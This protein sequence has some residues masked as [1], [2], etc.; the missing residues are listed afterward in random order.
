MDCSYL[1]IIKL[2]SNYVTFCTH[3]HLFSFPSPFIMADQT[4]SH[5][6]VTATTIATITT[7]NNYGNRVIG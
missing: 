1:L 5:D 6:S 7:T 3:L 2:G 4:S